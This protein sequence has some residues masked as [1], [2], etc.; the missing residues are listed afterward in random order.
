MDHPEVSV[1]VNT[2]NR[3]DSL[4][5]TIESFRHLTYHEFEVIVVNGPSTDHTEAV[6]AEFGDSIKVRRCAEPNLSKSRNIG[7]AAAAGELIAFIDDDAI[8]EPRW[9]EDLVSYHDGDQVGA[10]GGLVFDHTGYDLQ[11]RFNSCDRLGNSR[12]D[13]TVPLDDQCFPGSLR[14]PYVPGGNAVWQRG[15]LLEVGG[16]DEEYEYFL[17]EVDVCVRMIDRGY[18]LRQHPR[19]A[20][21]HKFLPSHLRNEGRALTNRYPVIKNKIYFSLVNGRPLLGPTAV[22]ADNVRFCE[23][24]L[25]DLD[26]HQT[27]GRLDP[28]AYGEAVA[29]IDRAWDD[30]I[31]AAARGSRR[32]YDEAALAHHAEKFRKFPTIA[33][34]EPRYRLAFVTQTLPPQPIGGIGR[35][36]LDLGRELGR[37][38]HDIRILTDGSGHDTMDFE[39][40]VWVHRLVK[41]SDQPTPPDLGA[42]P[43][44][45]WQNASRVAREIEDIAAF[46]GLDAVYSSMWDVESIGVQGRVAVTNLVALVTTLAITLRT[47]PEWENDESFMEGFGRPMLELERRLLRTAQGIHAIS[48]TIRDEVELTSGVTLDH[49][50]LRVGHLGITDRFIDAA[51][52]RSTADCR[53]LFVGRF[54]KRKGIDVLLAALPG[55]LTTHPRLTVEL[56]GKHDLPSESGTSYAEE[57]TARH[58][59][60]GWFDRVMIRG[61]V[62]DVALDQAFRDCDIFVAPSRFESFGLIY[63]EAMSAARPVVAAR[64]GA[65]T[66]I[67]VDGVTGTLVDSGDP[68]ALESALQHLVDDPEA[69]RTMSIAGRERFLHHFTVA[70][71]ADRFLALLG[72]IE[73][74]NPHDDRW[75]GIGSESEATGSADGAR[76]VAVA[77]GSTATCS[78]LAPGRRVLTLRLVSEP[79]AE[80]AW[81]RISSGSWSTIVHDDGANRYREVVLGADGDH[82]EVEAGPDG[83]VLVISLTLLR[84]ELEDTAG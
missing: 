64:S 66:E 51:P 14:F 33:S 75:S 13:S 71:M 76:G 36:M 74:I 53:I 54:E 82:L 43:I 6:I 58:G 42:V 45:I 15:P 84:R 8:P 61:E 40:G 28:D 17:D 56:I 57:F 63:V 21:H 79:G 4:R 34:P 44:R 48:A 25:A 73:V 9:L 72:E 39:D 18:L 26:F 69:R 59:E 41:E 12:Y 24:H 38:G 3:A 80:R 23:A 16:F 11:C 77:P 62:D 83:R 5:R 29:A 78:P 65:A 50:G 20:I 35:Y 52:H 10:S 30:G 81:V 31:A 47:R 27:A 68:A 60:S 2:L 22:F 49:D 70:A 55:L 1:I 67:V 7:I 46:D 19:G 32:L 37:R